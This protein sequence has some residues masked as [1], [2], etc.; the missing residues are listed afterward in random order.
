MKKLL[1]AFVAIVLLIII[2]IV[3]IT[4]LVDTDRVKAMLSEQVKSTT[5]ADL[6]VSGDLSWRFFPSL[7]FTLGQT[8]LRNA[9]GYSEQNLIE[10]KSASMDL[11]V[12]PLFD[13]KIEV[14]QVTFSGVKI[15][16]LTKANG[17]TNVD[18][19]SQGITEQNKEQ[20]TKEQPT[21]PNQL[22]ER[23]EFSISVAGINI[24]QGQLLLRD[25]VSKKQQLVSNID[26]STSDI[27][28]EKA[29]PV[30]VSADYAEQGLVARFESSFN[31][32]VNAQLDVL[33]I[34]TMQTKAELA[35]DAIPKGQQTI[36]M[37][38]D[39]RYELGNNLATITNLKLNA[40][41]HELTGSASVQ[42]AKIPKIRFNLSSEQL[43]VDNLLAQFTDSNQSTTAQPAATEET[44]KETEQAK[45][46]A[47]T[48]LSILSAIDL[49]GDL[50][51]SNVA[52]SNAQIE[53]VKMQAKISQGI[54][55]LSGIQA[56]LYQGQLKGN[57]TLNGKTK[58]PT[59]KVQQT[60]TGVQVRPLMTAVAEMD[61]LAGTMN[62]SINLTGTGLT[63]PQIR[64]SLAGEAK[65]KFT[66]GALHGINIAQ[67]V[68]KGKAQLK[69]QSV[70]EVAEKKT[71]FSALTGSFQIG[72]GVA[73]T[74]DIKM[75]SPALRVNGKGH[76]NLVSE[77]LD[78]LVDVT[79]VG[80]LKGQGGKSE[81]E[82]A[83]F[84]VP[85]KVSG[86]WQ[87]PAF[88]LDMEALL[89]QE[90]K[91]HGEQLKEKLE[92]AIDDKVK[93]EG[94]KELLKKLP[95][96]GLFN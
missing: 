14:G 21:E 94:A 56:Q 47:S 31:L 8:E 83:G 24:E 7:G 84:N 34:T 69:G 9:A 30:S 96:K 48:D 26:F 18:E 42:Q 27:A 13:R 28:L 49:L 73:R 67:M 53:Q 19:F 66:D 85:I 33:T 92:Q 90:M 60:L 35:G 22:S 76:T 95:L 36:Q 17:E 77:S 86:S 10:F 6:V 12:K 87:A 25:E 3:T 46:P 40:F 89:K 65:L 57:L 32:L 54:A 50:S 29:I 70:D 51:I 43:D 44:A 91:Q 68:R 20:S 38:A 78:F 4:S 72:K 5:G 2:A 80:S 62:A 37:D 15:N 82:L 55:Q 93:D 75:E 16:I 11:A 52:V 41:A 58:V 61:K 74:Q 64:K 79:V 45:S 59:F 1:Y 88:A 63:D 39:L 71:D 23:P 81:D